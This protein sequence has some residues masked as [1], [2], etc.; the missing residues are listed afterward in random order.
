M[1]GSIT[2]LSPPGTALWFEYNP[3]SIESTRSVNWAEIEMPGLNYPLQQFVS[4]G[5]KTLTLE[6][7]FN[8]DNYSKIFDVRAATDRV[9]K[10]TGFDANTMDA[11]RGAVKIGREK[12]L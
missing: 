10:I 9:E 4:G 5:L 11:L 12:H 2:P 6:V 3:P 7:Y 1:K 8:A